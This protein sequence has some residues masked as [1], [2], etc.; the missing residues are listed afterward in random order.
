M[1]RYVKTMTCWSWW[2]KGYYLRMDTPVDLRYTNSLEVFGRKGDLFISVR[3]LDPV[4][5]DIVWEFYNPHLKKK[6]KKRAAI[7][8]MVR[9]FD[10]HHLSWLKGLAVKRFSR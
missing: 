2:K 9:I 6:K 1:Y 10:R 8:R 4:S 5:R 7:Y 3:E